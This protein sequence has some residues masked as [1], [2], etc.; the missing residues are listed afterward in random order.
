VDGV[1][2]LARLLDPS[3]ASALPGFEGVRARSVV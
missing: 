3:V 1:E 2:L